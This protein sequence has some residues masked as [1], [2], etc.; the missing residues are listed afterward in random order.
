M[1]VRV[2]K[3]GSNSKATKN[4]ENKEKDMQPLGRENSAAQCLDVASPTKM[5]GTNVG[6]QSC[7]YPPSMGIA[8]QENMEVASVANSS[9]N[10]N[11]DYLL[12]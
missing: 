12:I 9:N 8:D 3:E 6:H 5:E 4:K 2:F 11:N 7:L 1:Y 10:S